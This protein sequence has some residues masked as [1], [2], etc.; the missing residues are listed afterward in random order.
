M[1]RGA[2]AFLEHGCNKW[3]S[4]DR[5]IKEF[6]QDDLRWLREHWETRI[7][8]DGWKH[9]ALIMP[10]NVIGLVMSKKIVARYLDLGVDV[11]TFEDE[12]SALGW[13]SGLEG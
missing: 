9:W 5:G 10:S 2:D 11:R 13:L 6:R 3:M 8:R 4:D 7:L 1:S 12:G